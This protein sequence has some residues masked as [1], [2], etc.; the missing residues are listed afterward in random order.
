MPDVVKI[1]IH[2]LTIR[3]WNVYCDNV[4]PLSSGGLTLPTAHFVPTNHVTALRI[5]NFIP[6][7]KNFQLVLFPFTLKVVSS[8]GGLQ[9]K[10]TL[11]LRSLPLPMHFIHRWTW[12]SS[13]YVM[14]IIMMASFMPVSYKLVFLQSKCIV[15]APSSVYSSTI[16]TYISS[17][18]FMYLCVPYRCDVCLTS[19]ARCLWKRHTIHS[20][21]SS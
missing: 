20:L 10:W 16:A 6:G 9:P 18:S 17:S 21:R 7:P 11:D 4:K 8:L 3:V 19:P 5:S 14:M 13:Q 1:G 12:K 15:I 2:F